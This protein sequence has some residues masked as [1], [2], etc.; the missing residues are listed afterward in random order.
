MIGELALQR[1]HDG[2]FR[3]RRSDRGRRLLTAR[4]E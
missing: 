1:L 2:D 3:R 4:D